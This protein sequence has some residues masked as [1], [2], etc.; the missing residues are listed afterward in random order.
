MRQI[1]TSRC[2]DI[3]LICSFRN[4][5]ARGLRKALAMVKKMQMSMSLMGEIIVMVMNTSSV[6]RTALMVRMMTMMMIRSGG[7]CQKQGQVM[8]FM[9]LMT[10]MIDMKTKGM[11]VKNKAMCSSM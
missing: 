3:Q 1:L 6:G 10:M 8:M 7:G 11:D 5:E 4:P 2:L 9:L